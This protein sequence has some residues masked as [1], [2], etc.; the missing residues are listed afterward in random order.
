LTRR[1]HLDKFCIE[2]RVV[3]AVRPKTVRVCV[4]V[5]FFYNKS[6]TA[7]MSSTRGG[8]YTDVI[9]RAGEERSYLRATRQ[10]AKP[11]YFAEQKLHRQ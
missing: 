5:C 2:D 7:V 10:C 1:R 11:G 8:T 6:F 9:L 3:Y 4:C